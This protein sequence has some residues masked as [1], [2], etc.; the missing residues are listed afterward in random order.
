MALITDLAETTIGI[1]LLDTYAKIML[2]RADQ[3]GLLLQV[4]HYVSE[5]ASS[6]GAA[7]V[8]DRTFAAPV[9]ELQP[10][11]DPLAIGYAW[12]KAQPEYV[13]AQDA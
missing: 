4:S 2:L 11:A 5:A 12:L 1:P 8:C 6:A 7:S 3:Q 10:G 9:T 13:A